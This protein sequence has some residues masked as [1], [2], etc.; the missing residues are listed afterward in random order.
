VLQEETTAYD[1]FSFV[2]GMI[3]SQEAT[4]GAPL[5][6]EGVYTSPSDFLLLS[7]EEK[8]RVH[9]F[10]IGKSGYGE[11]AFDVEGFDVTDVRELDLRG[12]IEFSGNP[13]SITNVDL[14]PDET[15]KPARGNSCVSK[16]PN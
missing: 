13:G 10:T 12:E 15:T 4:T 7:D 6:P 3:P 5:L 8:S 16:N 11:I 2:K 9:N 14:Y 1:L